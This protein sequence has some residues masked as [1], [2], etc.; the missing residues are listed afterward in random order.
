MRV[1]DIACSGVIGSGA[2]PRYVMWDVVWSCGV[3]SMIVVYGG[4]SCCCIA[5]W[6]CGL[7]CVVPCCDI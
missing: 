2:M 6:W 7:W 1:H 5:L 3:V 4:V